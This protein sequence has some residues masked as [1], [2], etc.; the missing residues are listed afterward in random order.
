[1]DDKEMQ[2]AQGCAGGCSKFLLGY[3]I[4]LLIV[5]VFSLFDKLSCNDSVSNV[6]PDISENHTTPTIPKIDTLTQ[7]QID[8]QLKLIK[9]EITDIPLK[10]QV[11]KYFSIDANTEKDQ[12]KNLLYNVCLNAK[13]KIGFKY[14]EHPTLI[15]LYAYK[16]RKQFSE[17]KMNWIGYLEWKSGGIEHIEIRDSV[18]NTNPF[19]NTSDIDI[20]KKKEIFA[21][22]G[23]WYK[24]AVDQ[25]MEKYPNDLKKQIEHQDK[26]E[27]SFKKQIEKKYRLKKGEFD[28][29]IF[30]GGQKRWSWE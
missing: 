14:H 6:T 29:I 7:K 28:A 20:E 3:A 16:N 30:E 18:T 25:A 23:K 19:G 15:Y 9:E 27:N 17:S 21:L 13:N 10:T 5:V 12:L 1:M 26:L 22:E 24:L 8:E 2:A 4:I 11:I